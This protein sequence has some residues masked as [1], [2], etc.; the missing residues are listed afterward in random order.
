MLLH[1]MY[2]GKPESIDEVII[3]QQVASPFEPEDAE[4]KEG[5]ALNI[6][7]P[8]AESKHD[9]KEWSTGHESGK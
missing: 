6:S 1:H 9:K 2:Y 7:E 4:A 8:K 3:Y 5:V